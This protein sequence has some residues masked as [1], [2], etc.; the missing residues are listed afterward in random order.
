MKPLSTFLTLSAGL[1]A[2]A[3]AQ[4]TAR[5]FTFDTE[6]PSSSSSSHDEILSTDTAR[7]ILAA[8]LGSPRYAQLGDV[9]EEVIG[10]LNKFGGRQEPIFG[11][12]SEGGEVSKLLVLWE[13]VNPAGMFL[14]WH[15]EAPWLGPLIWSWLTDL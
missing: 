3:S 2:S 11:A 8:R 15:F 6:Q 12:K 9:D 7:L 4:S 5:I 14:D 13:G 1:L 10:Q